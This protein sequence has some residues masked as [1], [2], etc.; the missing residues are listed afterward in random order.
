MLGVLGPTLPVPQSVL[1]ECRE[2][3]A[4]DG[5]RD[6]PLRRGRA[7]WHPDAEP[8]RRRQHVHRDDV[9]RGARLHQRDPT[10]DAH[11]GARHHRRRRPVLLHRRAQGGDGGDPALC[12]RPADARHVR[13]HRAAAEAGDRLGQRLCGRRRQRACRSCATSR[14]PRKARSFARSAR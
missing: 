5:L 14:S 6:D 13:E 12:R 8:A 7:G 4:A 3:S 9:P 1:Q 2:R 11:P 10:R